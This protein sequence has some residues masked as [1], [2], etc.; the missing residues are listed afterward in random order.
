M[1]IVI[2]GQYSG[3]SRRLHAQLNVVQGASGV[4]GSAI[5]KAFESASGKDYEVIPLS[6]SQSGNGL[7]PLDLTNSGKVEEFLSSKKPDCEL[8]QS[9][10]LSLL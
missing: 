5:R 4:L 9:T 7:L 3:F 8:P 1:K 2:T 10:W 6:H